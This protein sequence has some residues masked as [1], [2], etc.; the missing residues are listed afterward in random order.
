MKKLFVFFLFLV[1]SSIVHLKAQQ[2][3]ES[4]PRHEVKFNLGS[5]IF[6]AFPEV[7]YEYILGQGLSVGGAMGFG[8]NTDELDEYSFRVT[9]FARWF[10]GNSFLTMKQPAKGIFLEGS[11]AVG[12]RDSYSYNTI[13]GN[14]WTES[15]SEKNREPKFSAGL[16]LALGYKFVSKQNWSAELFLGLGNSFVYYESEEDKY[17][18]K[19]PLYPRIGFSIGKRF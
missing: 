11:F 16:A 13:V 7:S 14:S 3:L 12:T 5:A 6:A 9:P 1:L 2:S 15:Y 10:F 8:F 18:P 4:T 17:N 19:I